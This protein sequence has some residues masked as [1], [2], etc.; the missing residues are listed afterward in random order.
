MSPTIKHI[1]HEHQT[2]QINSNDL[3]QVDSNSVEEA[4]LQKQ[5]QESSNFYL[6]STLLGLWYLF[7]FF[8]LILNKYILTVLGGEASHLGQIQ[9]LMSVIFGGLTIYVLPCFVQ[10]NGI[11]EK[12]LKFI[13]NMSILGILR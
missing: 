6:Q 11:K 9:M 13:R 12:R 3:Q 5:K 1:H 7:S 4:A 2:T 10:T 8:T